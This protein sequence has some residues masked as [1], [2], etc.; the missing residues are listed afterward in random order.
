M[1]TVTQWPIFWSI[2][3]SATG[4]ECTPESVHLQF[5]QLNE[6][7][8]FNF[9][10]NNNLMPSLEMS[11]K[12]F[13]KWQ[14]YTTTAIA[15]FSASEQTLCILFWIS[16][17]TFNSMILNI[18]WSG[19]PTALSGCYMASA[20][21]NCCC[22]IVHSVHTVDVTLHMNFII[23]QPCASAVSLYSKPHTCIR[24]VHV[25][26]AVTCHLHFWRKN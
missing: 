9:S 15:L 12:C 1:H 16:D 3:L 18:Q 13:T 21:W 6:A 24:R 2:M 7:L 20:T 25:C 5:L 4:T 10:M 22:F 23:I 8:V 26:L 17:C 11:P 14:T 19:V